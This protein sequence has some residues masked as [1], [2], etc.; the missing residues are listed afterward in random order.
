M[1]KLIKS[2]QNKHVFYFTTLSDKSSSLSFQCLHITSAQFN[3]VLEL[4]S[5]GNG[6]DKTD[7]PISL[8]YSLHT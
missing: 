1:N 4:Y 2:K 3:V 7:K 6:N 5:L 8:Q